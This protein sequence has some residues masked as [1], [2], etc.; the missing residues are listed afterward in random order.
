M[1]G[2]LCHINKSSALLKSLVEDLSSLLIIA[3]WNTTHPQ[4]AMV[5][6][7]L[8]TEFVRFSMGRLDSVKLLNHYIIFSDDL[9]V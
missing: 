6:R 3:I 2:E 9:S 4:I 5:L 8:G 1:A 7:I